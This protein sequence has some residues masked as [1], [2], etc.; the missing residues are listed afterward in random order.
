VEEGFQM[1]SV[2]PSRHAPAVSIAQG[3]R[4]AIIT[5]ITVMISAVV[6]SAFLLSQRF[7][8]Q[9]GAGY[10]HRAEEIRD[11]LAMRIS[12]S[13]YLRQSYRN[14]LLDANAKTES[15]DFYACAVD[16]PATPAD[17]HTVDA[18]GQPIEHGIRLYSPYDSLAT[19]GVAP[20]AITG[21]GPDDPHPLRYDENG[22]RCAD[23]APLAG[24]PFEAYARF[25][26]FCGAP[27]PLSAVD[28]VT[29]IAPSD[30]DQA[31]T[32]ITL[33]TVRQ[34][35]GLP[36]N[37]LDRLGTVRDA[38]GMWHFFVHAR[39][40]WDYF[41]I[42]PNPAGFSLT[43]HIVNS[44]LVPADYQP[45]TGITCPKGLIPFGAFCQALTI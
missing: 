19:N 30:C 4:G 44:S 28:A 8:L 20:L 24:C 17:C 15:P 27:D 43:P 2:Q 7:S 10:H 6:L 22:D 45:G 9:A 3:E 39:T 32:M 5:I 26:A 13:A 29:N 38:T 35:P 25:V 18:V 23:Q 14:A 36:P 41:G 33:Y 42:M 16:D 21:S 11:I 1:G 37:V 34:T 12:R 40:D 31:Y